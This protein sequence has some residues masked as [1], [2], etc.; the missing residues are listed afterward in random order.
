LAAFDA[1]LSGLQA[2]VASPAAMR[3]RAQLRNLIEQQISVANQALAAEQKIF[4]CELRTY[5]R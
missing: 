5:R 2:S 1:G 3:A 4:H